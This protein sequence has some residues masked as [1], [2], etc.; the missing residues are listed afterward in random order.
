MDRWRGKTAVVTGASAGIGYAITTS[1]L[2]AGINVV[3]CARNPTSLEEL[4][5]KLPSHAGK[6]TALKSDLSKEE[7]ILLLFKEIQANFGHAD[8]L[9]NN[10][11]TAILGNL[12]DADT[13]GWRTMLDLNILATNI[14]T[15]EFLKLL[16]K[17]GLDTGHIININSVAGHTIYPVNMGS[18]YYSA[19]KHM[20]TALTKGLIHEL[21]QK[22]SK[23]RVTSLSPGLVNTPL[24]AN[25]Q[26]SS[27]HGQIWTRAALEGKDIADAVLYI[28][29]TP[30]N[31]VVT[32]LTITPGPS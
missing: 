11:G 32:E 3:G 15:R 6:L 26:K 30:P 25:I 10:A 12:S 16:E 31:V 4:Q 21:S 29:G 23:I 22:K 17:D 19:T 9:I 27:E 28:L 13:E 14:C 7:E 18:Y 24:V 2:E 5:S 20:I 1:L 8:I